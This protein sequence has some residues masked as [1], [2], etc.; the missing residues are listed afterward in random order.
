MIIR[1][2]GGIIFF[3]SVEIRDVSFKDIIA[4]RFTFARKSAIL[5]KTAA[6]LLPQEEG[7]KG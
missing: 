5:V 6:G 1:L 2:K 4:E 3:L 7:V